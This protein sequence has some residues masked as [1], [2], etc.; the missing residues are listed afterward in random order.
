MDLSSHRWHFIG[1]GGAGMSALADALLD[2]GAS[3]TGSDLSA[4]DATRSLEARG[5]RVSIGHAAA[6]LGDADH[7]VYTGAVPADNPEIV[8]ARQ[9]N[10]PLIR[11][12]ELLG[13]LMDLRRGVAVAGTHGKTT[14]SSMLAWV[15]AKSGRD[16]SYMVGGTIRGLGPGGHWGGGPELV[17]E[18]DEYD[19]S[20]LQLRPEVAIIT[21]ID[22]DHLEYYGST[23]AIYA[24]FGEFAAN[25]RPGGLLVMCAD[26]LTSMQLASDLQQTTAP[27]RLQ[28]YGTASEALWRPTAITPNG[29][30]GSDY[31]VTRNGQEVVSV[32]LR[33]PGH[34]NVLNSLAVFAACIELGL[35]PEEVARWLAE[36]EGAGRRFEVKGE[37]GGITVVDDYAHHPTE[38]TATLQAARERYPNRRLLV[39]FQPHTYTRT[40]D[41]LN[42]F[43]TSLQLADRT[44]VTEIYASR[45]QD[46]L[47]MS[48][49]MIVERIKG[50]AEF[51]PTLKEGVQTLLDDVASGDVVI[52]MGAGDIWKAGEELLAALSQAQD[53]E[54]VEP[55]DV[56]RHIPLAPKLDVQPPGE[57]TVE[58][59][60]SAA[61]RFTP[62][63][64]AVTFKGDPASEI[65]A[66]TGLK[67]IR[68]E[69][70]SKHNS[71][72]VGG[73]ASYFVVASSK[74][75]LVAVVLFARERGL[76]YLVLGNGTNVL[77]GDY[78]IDGLVIHNKAQDISHELLD[79]H[80][81]LWHVASG[82]LF[83]RLARITCEQGWTGLE[84]S[85]SV[86]GSVGGGVVSN[87]GA[88]GKD[89]YDDLVSVE[90]LTREGNIEVWSADT[91]EM[92]YRTSRFKAHGSRALSNPEVILSASITLYRDT[93]HTCEARMREYLAERQATQPPGKTAGSTFKNPPG[94]YAGYLI[95]QVGLKGYRHGQAQFSPKHANFMMNLGGATTADVLYLMRLAQDRVREQFGIDLEPEI[96]YIGE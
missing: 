40:R 86:P 33:V 30:G 88:H 21:N 55:V 49:R 5:A 13:Q 79:E 68:D 25:V 29:T 27:F 89:L 42:D 59:A 50:Q 85:N 82:V 12:A 64:P 81:S 38:I 70:M 41:F 9:R 48:G 28:F 56:E 57:L 53:D 17:A 2:L 71:L 32:S 67:V 63:R 96:E 94:N 8:A 58:Q 90:V 39:L 10:L 45:E 11:R 60:Q 20:F 7:V 22:S 62:S 92:G 75:Q 36:F 35:S 78:G 18:A 43:A 19:R 95:E 51:V 87:A 61:A 14:T 24:A 65:E 80:R 73:P 83:S 44:Y 23:D 54:A 26:D 4:S 74:A 47:G 1:I 31:V 15:L 66:A 34:H 46:T 69:P 37:I 72:R 52:T 3:V 16:P 84:W 76:P 6:N 77:V 91:L 93:D